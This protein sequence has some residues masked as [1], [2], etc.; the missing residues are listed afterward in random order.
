MDARG[1]N[2]GA[3]NAMGTMVYMAPEQLQARVVSPAADVYALGVML[4]ELLL[5]RTP[6]DLANVAVLL[7]QKISQLE[8]IDVDLVPASERTR[9][10]LR[11]FTR[12]DPARRPSGPEARSHAGQR[13]RVHD[14]HPSACAAPRWGSRLD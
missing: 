11:A 2:T 4:A 13:A 1:A 8:G 12:A 6:Y 3:G 5:G 14:A 9:A 7:Q 10:L